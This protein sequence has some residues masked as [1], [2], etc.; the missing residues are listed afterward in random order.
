MAL[1]NGSEM[2]LKWLSNGSQVVQM[3]IAS[4]LLVYL[5]HDFDNLLL[6]AHN[7]SCDLYAIVSSKAM[8]GSC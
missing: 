7:Q 6:W 2:A 4:N 8:T 1:I 3:V 5:S